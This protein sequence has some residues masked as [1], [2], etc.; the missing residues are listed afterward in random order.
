[1]QPLGEV[2]MSVPSCSEFMH[3]AEH[4][5]SLHDVVP[6]AQPAAS[7][8]QDL[9]TPQQA[10]GAQQQQFPLHE[11]HKRMTLQQ[12][13]EHLAGLKQKVRQLPCSSVGTLVARYHPH[14][15]F[16]PDT[17]CSTERSGMLTCYCDSI[18]KCDP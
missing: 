15:R 13:R 5:L 9:G 6:Q 17:M 1:M 10:M 11:R 14:K 7:P 16:L 4:K 18:N 12:A 8:Q 3:M 2:D